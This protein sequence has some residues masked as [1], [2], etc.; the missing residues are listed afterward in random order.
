MALS[1]VI[2]WN[3]PSSADILA[4]QSS[5]TALHTDGN[6]WG[7]RVHGKD[8]KECMFTY[9]DKKIIQNLLSLQL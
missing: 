9:K 8:T 4:T 2:N 1:Y 5:S 7:G 6:D 3:Q